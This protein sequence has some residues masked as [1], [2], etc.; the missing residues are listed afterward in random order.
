[1]YNFFA[2]SRNCSS[3]DFHCNNT[4]RCIPHTW[5]CDK[6]DD[7]GDGS[8][9][10]EEKCKL[11]NNSTCSLDKFECVNKKCILEVIVTIYDLKLS[12]YIFKI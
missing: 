7:C 6:D 11:F 1:M 9:E 12:V 5:V 10:N 4:G 8:D 3:S 2:V